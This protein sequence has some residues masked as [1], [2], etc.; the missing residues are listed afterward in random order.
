MCGARARRRRS[1]RPSHDPATSRSFCCSSSSCI[2][3]FRSCPDEHDARTPSVVTDMSRDP[4]LRSILRDATAAPRSRRRGRRR[5]LESARRDASRSSGKTRSKDIA[6]DELRSSEYC[7]YRQNAALALSMIPV[8]ARTSTAYRHVGEHTL[9]S[10]P[11]GPSAL[12]P[13]LG[14]G[15]RAAARLPRDDTVELLERRHPGLDL[16]NAVVPERRHA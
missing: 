4:T 16:R 12:W 10:P 2:R 5:G 7:E 6:A 8:A 14:S 1:T 15:S 3:R 11:C 9:E 13:K